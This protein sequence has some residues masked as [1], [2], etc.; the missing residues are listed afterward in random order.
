MV[1]KNVFCV[2]KPEFRHLGQNSTFL[3]NSI[4]ENHIKAADA[5]GSDH[6]QAIA[7]VVD[8]TYFSFFNWLHLSTS[9]CLNFN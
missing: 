8:F 1:W 2:V 9:Q 5:V 6:D 7:V 4:M 3:G